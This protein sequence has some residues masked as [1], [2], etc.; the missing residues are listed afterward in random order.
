VT[1]QTLLGVSQPD[2]I[3]VAGS[4]RGLQGLGSGNCAKHPSTLASR[5][6][7]LHNAANSRHFAGPT[8]KQGQGASPA[9]AA[10]CVL[11]VAGVAVSG[12]PVGL[13]LAAAVAADPTSSGHAMLPVMLIGK[14]HCHGATLSWR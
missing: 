1:V 6:R 5:Q 12:V 10:A 8:C 9:V 4:C 7:D 11:G 13:Q 2:G 14:R 3:A